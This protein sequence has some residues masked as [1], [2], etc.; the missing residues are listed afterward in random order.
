MTIS[1]R[2][3]HQEQEKNSNEAQC[4]FKSQY[5]SHRKYE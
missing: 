5:V 2:I 3:E 1:Y 4:I